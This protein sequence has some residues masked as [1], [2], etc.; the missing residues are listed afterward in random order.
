MPALPT[1]YMLRLEKPSPGYAMEPSELAQ[2]VAGIR[3][4]TIR[5]RGLIDASEVD[6]AEDE[7]HWVLTM[8]GIPTLST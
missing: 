8:T 3:N 4:A 6:V 5:R 1:T 2:I 7:L